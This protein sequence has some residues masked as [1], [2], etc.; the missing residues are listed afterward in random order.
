MGIPAYFS[1]IIKNYP[2]ILQKFNKEFIVDNLF[3]D[4]NSIIYDSFR[5][6]DFENDINDY[7]KK[8]INSV[9]KK[10]ENYIKDIGP[11]N[12]VYIAFDGVAPIAKLNQQK[13]RRYKSSFIHSYNNTKNEWDS[14]CITPGTEFMN[15]L[16]LQIKYYFR[17]SA[18]FKVKQIIVDGSDI[19]GE[20]EHKVFDYI[21]ENTEIIKTHKSVIYGLDADLI[22]LTIN[23]LSYCDKMYL[24]RETPSFIKSID[25]SLDPD[26][27]YIVNIPEFKNQLVYYLNNDMVPENKQQENKLYDYIFLCF[28]L[29]ND[30]LPHFPSLNIRTSGMDILMETYRNVLKDKNIIVNG[31]IKW[32]HMRLL[33]EELAKNEEENIQ[34]EYKIRNKQE[35]RPQPHDENA[36]K[37]DKEMLHCP[38]TE[39]QIEKYINPFDDYWEHRYYDMLFDIEI[40]DNYRKEISLNYLEGLEWT[41]KYY[42][43]GCCDW[44]WFYKYHYPPLFKDLIK[45]VPYFDGDMIEYKP[46]NPIHEHVQLSYVLPR[47]SL[48]LLPHK[49]KNELLTNY[50]EYYKDD[51]E[52]LW[53]F[54]KYF[55]ECHVEF[56]LLEIEQLEK[57]I[58]I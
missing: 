34:R 8:V 53:S 11:S 18:F 16:N 50:G 3:L 13:N 9:C 55:W 17:K 58:E 48:N 51:Y 44:R 52:F 2:N 19:P 24:F 37:F 39:R 28:F 22:M 36:N 45:F 12:L 38:I 46:K 4:S 31:K 14:T 56:P 33:I 5:E 25:K 7:E 47:N 21:R 54:C 41:W 57:I 29:G 43:T 42:S 20:G 23:N 15:K 10:I 49:I 1:Y 6:I 30:F 40:N 27:L 32:K 35:K 26:C